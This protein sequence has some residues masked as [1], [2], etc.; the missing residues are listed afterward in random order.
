MAYDNS[1]DNEEQDKPETEDNA[2][3][4]SGEMEDGKDGSVKVSEEFQKKAGEL[5]DGL[6]TIPEL[7]FLSDLVSEQRTKL[8]KSEK[9]MS[10][11][12]F[13]TENMPEL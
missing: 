1:Q 4:E 11:P 6:R 10:K 8:M 2:S 12:D 3:E 7:N 9:K 5:V 13:S